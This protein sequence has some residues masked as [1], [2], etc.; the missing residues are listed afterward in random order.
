MGRFLAKSEA[1]FWAQFSLENLPH[2]PRS[3]FEP[4]LKLTNFGKSP[5]PLRQRL[6][7]Q[8][9]ILPCVPTGQN[10]VKSTIFRQNPDFGRFW[11]AN[12]SRGQNRPFLGPILTPKESEALRLGP[13]MTKNDPFWPPILEP[14]TLLPPKWVK[15]DPFWGQKSQRL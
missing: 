9:S 1:Q 15:N 8:K 10:A 2:L 3:I 6:F 14:L 5:K 13:K 12:A 11:P 4:K 7:G